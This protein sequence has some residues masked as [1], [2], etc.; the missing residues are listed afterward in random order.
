ME[1]YKIIFK[2]LFLSSIIITYIS[3]VLTGYS[4]ILAGLNS[5]TYLK[6]MGLL[7]IVWVKKK[8]D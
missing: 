5:N 4:K 1:V 6:N 8:V 7:Q 3:P 2:I